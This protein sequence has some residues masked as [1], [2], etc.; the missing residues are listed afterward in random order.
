MGSG[1]DT[2]QARRFLEGCR[3]GMRT[4]RTRGRGLRRYSRQ[5]GSMGLSFLR[6]AWKPVILLLVLYLLKYNAPLKEDLEEWIDH[7]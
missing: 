3:R 2:K 1:L 7:A 5:I 6:V 4:K